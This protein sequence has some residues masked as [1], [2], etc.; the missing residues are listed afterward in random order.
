[1][2]VA[3]LLIAQDPIVVDSFDAN[4][5]DLAW[6]TNESA[7]AINQEPARLKE[8]SGSLRWEAKA[9]RASITTTAIPADWSSI[10]RLSFWA[11]LA[12]EKERT[13]DV[14]LRER[15]GAVRFWRKFTLKPQTWVAVELGP[16]QFRADGV[17]SWK[18]LKLLSLVLR[19]GPSTVY[20]DSLRLL[21]KTGDRASLLEPDDSLVKRAFG[22]KA[23]VMRATTKN[24]RAFSNAPM[25]GGKLG[26]NLEEFYQVFLKTLGLPAKDLDYPV[27]LVI[28]TKREDYVDFAVR[29][30][31]EVYGAEADARRIR[32]DGYT[33][34]E[35][36]FTSYLA[37][38]GE[39][40]PVF[41]HEVCH[42]LVSRL[43]GLR[44]ANGATWV[45]EGICWF[46]QNEYLPQENLAQEVDR[47]FDGRRPKLADFNDE[48]ASQGVVLL[49]SMLLIGYFVKEKAEKRAAIFEA[50]AK[51]ADLTALVEQ[52]LKTD[53]AAF[54]A[55]WQA[56]AKRAYRK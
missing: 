41:Y 7:L 8:G 15:E 20:L 49:Q 32:S 55:D 44:G 12:D 18:S 45:E 14:E 22:D 13:I 11:W 40:R 27:T 6:K 26:A 10:G 51:S 25:D 21:P 29:T 33:F 56:W 4:R 9:A 34:F 19:D 39:K 50:L 36:S 42:Q 5:L 43:L 23:D 3:L 35:Y 24:F 46:L 2:L 54:E 1:M 16:W 37:A 28:H 48:I 31:R 17:P 30:A 53:L 38:R 52:V 47:L